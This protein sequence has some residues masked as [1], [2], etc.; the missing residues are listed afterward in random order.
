MIVL[1]GVLTGLNKAVEI[2]VLFRG[3]NNMLLSFIL[4]IYKMVKSYFF[5]RLKD[6]DNFN[7]LRTT[8][9]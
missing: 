8:E 9:G 2:K 6:Y 7:Y 3:R 1:E 5:P 4:I